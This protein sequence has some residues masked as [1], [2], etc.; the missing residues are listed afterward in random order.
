MAGASLYQPQDGALGSFPIVLSILLLIPIYVWFRGYSKRAELS[1][2]IKARKKNIV[3]CGIFSLFVLALS[4]RV[5]SVLL[6]NAPYEK[7][8]LILLTVLT[9]VIVEKTDLS[10]FGFT[11]KRLGAALF[12][13]LIFFVLLNALSLAI[14]YSLI[15]VLTNQMAFQSYNYVPFLLAMPFMTFCVGISEEGL[16]RGYM[17][18]HL[19]KICTPRNAILIQ[20]LLFG[21]WHFVWNLSPFNPARMS[22]YI[23]TTFLVGLLFG[24]FYHKARSLT[25]L[26]FAH[27]LWNSVPQ[28]IVDNPSALNALRAIHPL[29]ETLIFY[30]PYLF[31]AVLTFFFL[32]YFVNKTNKI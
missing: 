31:T 29:S 8:P 24:Y 32:K 13:G 1:Q 7:T 10:A 2:E 15:F 3:L 18:T 20:A 6:F 11:I 26:V 25:P 14:V 19:E 27:G 9:I 12:H 30:M 28:G 17:Q 21:L 4:I 23:A 16:F 22:L 5:P